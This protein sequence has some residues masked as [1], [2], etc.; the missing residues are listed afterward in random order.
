LLLRIDVFNVIYVRLFGR[1]RTSKFRL[2]TLDFELWTLNFELRMTDFRR[3]SSGLFGLLSVKE[4]NKE[5]EVRASAEA[6][7]KPEVRSL[8]PAD[9]NLQES[10]DPIL[11][12]EISNSDDLRFS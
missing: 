7:K 8:I 6:E 11:S 5:G 10:R 9:V 2:R 1:L 12:I 4:S 3:Y